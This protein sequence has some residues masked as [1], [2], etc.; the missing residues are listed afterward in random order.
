MGETEQSGNA[1][2]IDQ[3]VDVD[4]SSHG[5]NRTSVSGGNLTHGLF[6]SDASDT[7]RP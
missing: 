2:R 4:L 7:L 6:P 1:L 5:D 3:I